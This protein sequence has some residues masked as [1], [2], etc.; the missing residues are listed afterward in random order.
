MDIVGQAMLYT[1]AMIHAITP[2]LAFLG[3]G[4]AILIIVIVVDHLNGGE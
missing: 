1:A 4:L 3:F 2:A